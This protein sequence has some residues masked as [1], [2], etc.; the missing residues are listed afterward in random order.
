MPGF[1][2][3]IANINNIIEI[4]QSINQYYWSPIKAIIRKITKIVLLIILEIA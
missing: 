2:T 1:Y 3:I 4:P